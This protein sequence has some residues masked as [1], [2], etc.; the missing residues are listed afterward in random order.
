MKRIKVIA[1]DVLN[2]EISLLCSYSECYTDVT[3]LHQGLHDT[4][5]KLRTSIQAAIDQAEEGFPYNYYGTAPMYDCIVL[6]YGLCSKGTEG[7]TARTLPLVIPRAHD[8]ITL[9]LGSKEKYN[10]IFH[11][12]PGTY[13]FSSGWIERGWQPGEIRVHALQKAYEEKY[14]DDNAEYLMEMEQH[15]MKEYRQAGYIHWTALGNGEH[16]RTFTQQSA[17]YMGWDYLEQDGESGLLQRI[18]NG[19][20]EEAEVLVVPPGHRVIQTYD[21]R[22]ITSI[23]E[24]ESP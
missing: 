24:E 3:F 22:I 4:P 21:E 12:Y 5:E 10:K 7:L 1:C 23:P 19:C 2:R 18:V 17:A 9:L 8:C 20:F 16:Y 6:A 15:W 13:W 14:G 11:K